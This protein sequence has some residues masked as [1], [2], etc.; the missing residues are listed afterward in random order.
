MFVIEPL[1]LCD[2]PN[3]RGQRIDH[4]DLARIEHHGD[5]AHRLRF[6]KITS[7]EIEQLVGRRVGDSTHQDA[8]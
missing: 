2:D 8:G 7:V 6:S 3:D 1:R 5:A 4:A